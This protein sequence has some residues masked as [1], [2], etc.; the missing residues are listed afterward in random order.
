M[1][2]SNRSDLERVFS[3]MNLYRA[4]EHVQRKKGAPGPDGMTV[5]E[6][7]RHRTELLAD[8]GQDVRN[9][10]FVP[11]PLTSF[12]KSD[13]RRELCIPSLRDR[14]ASRC[15]ADNLNR[16]YEPVQH[17]DSFAYRPGKGV[18]SALN[19]AE[20]LGR[21]HGHVLHLDIARYFDA[22]PHSRLHGLLL[23]WDC[24]VVLAELALDFVKAPRIRRRFVDTPEVGI[25]Q[26]SPLAP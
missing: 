12:L 19:R 6:F 15:L 21:G 23:E 16:R 17:P 10:R 22:I 11:G 14:I 20:S 18:L 3:E 26:G 7:E 2:A 5:A 1:I 8:L 13:G 25:P 4:W 9:G 24:P